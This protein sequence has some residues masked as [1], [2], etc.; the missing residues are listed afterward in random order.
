MEDNFFSL[1][2]H[3]L[4][5]TQVMARVRKALGVELPLRALFEAPTVMTLARQVEQAQRGGEASTPMERRG[6]DGVLPLSFAQQ[7]LWFLEQL[8]PGNSDYN[9]PGALRLQGVL[10]VGALERSFQ[11]LVRRHE[12]LRT[13]LPS[14]EGEPRQSILAESTLRMLHVDLSGLNAAERQTEVERLAREEARAPFNL[15]QGPLLRVTLLKLGAQ[16]H[17]LLLTMHHIVSDGWSLGVLVKEV[18]ALYGAYAAGKES[19]L[20]ELPLQYADYSAW[21]RERLS[22]EVLDAQLGYWKTKLQGLP[23]ALE[24]PTDRPRPALRTSKGAQYGVKLDGA[25]TRELKALS[26]KQGATLY[27]TLLAAFQTLLHRYTGQVDVAV[28]SPIAN[29]TRVET[30]GLIGFFVNTLVMRG[31][32]SGAPGFTE[33]L[34]RVKG[35]T[36]EAYAHQEVPFEKLVEVL[37]PAR[38]LARTALFQ[39]MLVLQNAPAPSLELGA[40][41]LE[42]LTVDSGT[43]KFDLTLSLVDGEEL[44]GFLEYSTDLFEEE[45]V[46]RL[47]GNFRRLLEAIIA[48]PEQSIATLPLL[49]EEE[50]Q[51]L[52]VTWNATA[53]A[54]PVDQTIHELF[55]AQA[56]R[57]PDAVALIQGPRRISY[58]E[59]NRRANQVAH[60][61]LRHGVG[62]DARVGLFIRRSPEV[63][64][65]MLGVLKAGGA[66]VPLDPGYPVER[67]RFVASDARLS[68]VLAHGERETALVSPGAT[69]QW[70]DVDDAAVAAERGTNPGLNVPPDAAAYIIYTSGSTGTPKGVVGLHRGAVNRFRWMWA[71]YPA[72]SDEVSALKTSSNF[73]DSVWETFGLML[74]GV[75]SV[76]L[77]EET[78]RSPRLLVEAL[79]AERVTRIVLVPSL[80]SVLLKDEPQLAQRLSQLRYWTSSGEALPLEL[81][82]LCEEVLPGRKLLNLYGSSEV[83]ADSTAVEVTSAQSVPGVPIGRP[84]DN[85][86]VYLLDARLQP[87]PL[88]VAGELYIGGAGLARGYLFRPDLTAERFIP[89][90]YSGVPG[91]RLYRTGDLCRYRRDGTLD[92]IGRVDRQVKLRGMR[93]ELGEVE[94]VLAQ[95]P[96][97]RDAVVALHAATPGGPRLV[98]YTVAH[99]TP[100]P[101]PAELRQYLGQQL[102]EYM[103]PSVFVALERL[104]LT[105]NGKVDRKALPA[106]TAEGLAVAEG[107]TAPRTAVEELLAGAWAE[108]L[109]LER[110][111]V[112][113]NFFALGGHSL[114]ATQVMARVRKALGV[115]LPLRALFETPTVATLARQVE[116][117]QRG[118][119]ASTPIE[120]RG[121]DGVLPLSFSQQ[122][123]WFLE[124]LQPGSPDYNIPAVLQLRGTLDVSALERSFQEVVRRHEVLRTVL[125]SVEGEPRQSIL[126]ESTLHLRQVDLSAL[127]VSAPEVERLAREEARSPFNLE[128]GPLLRVTLLKLGEQ[129]HVLLLTMHHI[130][131]DGWSLGVLVKEVTA[132]YG[133]YVAGKE[134]PLAELPL[135]YADYSAWQR[136][137]LSGEV[138]EAQLGYWKTKLQGL[139][140]ALELPTDRSRPALRTSKGAQYGVKLDGA[141]TR[142]L[143]ALSRKQGATLYMT[144]LAAFQTLLHRYTGQVDVAVGSP[145]AN[146]TR[147]ETEGLIGFFVNTLVMRG[148]LSGAPG[149]TELLGRVKGTTLEA[150]AH[151]EVPFE[152]LVE[153]LAP[154]RDLARTALFQV[155]LVLQNAPAPSLEL[156]AVKLETLAVDSGT[157][158]FDL[159]LSLVDGEELEGWLEY[160]TDLF[161]EETVARLMGNFR[162]LLQGIVAK[163]EQ[164]IA[165]LPLLSEEERQ[166]LLVTWNATATARPVD[167]TI[168]ELFEAQAARTPDAVALIAGGER[169]SYGDLAQRARVRA[170]YLQSLGVGPETVVALYLERSAETVIWL[171]AILEAGGVY[172][173]LDL[174]APRER[175]AFMLEDARASVLLTTSSLL[176][177]LPE[178]AARVVCSDKASAAIASASPVAHVRGHSARLAYINYTSG[179]TGRPKGVSIPHGAV[180]R[181]A[182]ASNYIRITREDVLLQFAPVS[183]DA[184]TFEIWAGLLNGASVAVADAGTLSLEELGR[185][186]RRDKVTTLWLTAPLFHQMV[187]HHLDD[188]RGVRNLLAGGDVLSPAHVLRAMEALPGCRIINGYGPTE[189]TTFTCCGPVEVLRDGAPVPIGRPLDDTQVY[190]L[191]GRLQ[192]VPVGVPG[193]LYTGGAGLARGYLHNPGLTGEKFIP[194]PFGPPG[195]RLYRT[196]DLARYLP[197]GR[198]EFLGRIDQ[199]VKIRG[200]RIEPAEIEAVLCDHPGV[201]AGV[202]EVIHTATREKR[203]V[204]Y[205]V[206]RSQPAPTSTELRQYLGQ[207]LPE[208]MVPSVFMLL[209]AMP[210]TSNGKVDRKALPAPTAEGL[211]VAEGYTAPRTAVEELLA[212]AWAEVL[213]LERVGVE[214]NFFALGGHSLLATQVMARVR[215][216]LGVELPLRAL[217][218][219]PTVATLARQV[220]QAQRGGEA[221][222][223][224]ERRGRDGVLPLSFAQQ[225]LWFLEQ[226]QPGNSDYNVPGA[227]RLQGV[228]D[229]GALERSFQE[230]VRRHE[231][232]CTVLPSVEGEPRQSI[233][234]ESSLRLA[235]VDLSGLNATERQAEV[236]RLAREEARA[237]FNLEQGPLLRVTLLKLDAQEHVLL[238]TM[239]HIVS[240]GWSLGVLVKEVSALYG[241]YVAGKESPLAELPL[242]YADYSAWQRERLQGEV[243]DAQLGYWKTKLQGL[244]PALELPTDRPRPALRTSKGAQYGVKLD[245]A[246]TRELKALSRK[247]GATL[248]MTLL[249]AFQTLL[250]RYTGQVDVAVGSPIANRTRVETEGLIGFFV[251]TLVM[252]GDLSGA[253]GFTELLG[254]VKGTTLE[255]YAHQE[256]PFEKLVEVLAPARDLAR[257]ALF[258]VM[259]V[260]QNAPAPSLELG[261][262]KLETLAVDSGTSKFDL[263]LS[264]V[265]GEELEGW[266][267]YSTDLFEEETVAR[268]MGNFRR[269]LQGI[270]AKPEQS[271][272]TLPLLSEEERQTLLVTWNGQTRPA[273]ST[274]YVHQLF[275]D[276]A[277]RAPDELAVASEE[278]ALSYREVN[279]RA[280]RLARHLQSLGVGPEV[281]VG[282]LME[283]SLEMLVG[284][285]G[286]LKA[287]GA[288]VPIAPSFPAQRVRY[289]LEDSRVPVLLTVSA[290]RDA[291]SAPGVH[292]LCLD[293]ADAVLAAQDDSNLP[294]AV[295]LENRVYVIYTS[296][297]TGMPKGVVVE[298]RQVLNYLHA[299]V[300]R[301]GLKPGAQYAM[302]QP[303]AVDSCKTVFIPA[304]CAGGTLHVMSRERAS[305]PFA[306]REY[307]QRRHIDVLKITPSHLAALVDACPQREMFPHAVLALGG[308]A[309]HW[310][311]IRAVQ[312]LAPSTAFHIH[313]GP[314]ETTVGMLTYAIRP[315]AV[316]RGVRVPLGRPLPNTRVFVLDPAMQPV[317]VGVT[318]EIFIG[319]ACVTRGYQDRP[320]LTAERY[321][322]DPFSATPG[323][324]LY[325]TGDQARWLPEG[326]I[327]FLGRTDHQVKIRGFRIELGEV[328]A[329][330]KQHDVVQSA[331]VI[332]R[333]TGT[334]DKRLVAYVVPAR[335]D[336]GEP[337]ALS[338]ALLDF[339]R[340]RLPDYMLPAEVMLL[341]ALPL[342]AMGKVALNALPVPSGESAPREAVVPPRTVLQAQLVEVWET[343][344]DTRPVGITDNFFQLGGHSLLAV[345]LLAAI[346]HRF[347]RG[348]SLA[349]LFRNPTIAHVA[350]LLESSAE[351]RRSP[352]MVTLRTGGAGTP[353]FLVHAVGGNVLGYVGLAR[354]LGPDRPVYGLQAPA[355]DAP[356][357]ALEEL[358]ALYNEEL[359]RVQPQGPYLLGGWSMG[360]VLAYEMARQ[361]TEQGQEVAT[362]ALLDTHLPPGHRA[363]VDG[364]DALPVMARFAAELLR[365]RQQDPGPFLE[366]F[367]R[368]EPEQQRT[369]SLESLRSAGVLGEESSV[370]DLRELLEVFTRNT[371]ALEAYRLR[372]SDLRAVMFQATRSEAP[373]G[374]AREWAAWA[375]GGVE[376][377]EVPGDHFTIL[378][379]AGVR[380]LA[381]Q[382]RRYLDAAD[383]RR[384][385]GG[386]RGP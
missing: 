232:L 294:N 237:P 221:S 82:R 163:P 224:M 315:S 157:S 70:V 258:Q 284:V 25:L 386:A 168:H 225:R 344:L 91:A 24:L 161:E 131:S 276:H 42:M 268:L 44:E 62:P 22:G 116:Q 72:G 2:G 148:D 18:T 6:R 166:T 12:V 195:S 14:V 216:A 134:S 155:M 58:A 251:N 301:F 334:G 367:L 261:E 272:A 288:Y 101:T 26:R 295:T 206:P 299:I 55:E 364:H 215:K 281:G 210:L 177:R 247:Q 289:I 68:L 245:G 384:E 297:S 4:L 114:L 192:P 380:E 314:T 204:A 41:K 83:S 156:G 9:V 142:E 363:V 339:L 271:I 124:Q 38:D 196:G 274:R 66:Y 257:T 150:Y 277:E 205:V 222:T 113:D 111:G 51:T 97:L 291:G 170:G 355:P 309:S 366:R 40:V 126:A 248:Y 135:Q 345:K 27:M 242:Q 165:T 239:H 219:T 47:M 244:P 96:A 348:I 337:R 356:A 312:P 137:R 265:D 200:F 329:A 273:P 218:E 304:M 115:E 260:L 106:P 103:V 69:L 373:E 178:S 379:G 17:V 310:E 246:L 252:R 279:R 99:Q 362:L 81:V 154:A 84:I 378:Q 238:L 307:F 354:E 151:Q 280:N 20:S 201:S 73:V 365:M 296:G 167:Q 207:Q 140:P 325:R 240:D 158:K 71:L 107:Y 61:L 1:G 57:T 374:L 13:V 105:P 282:I 377:H 326:D 338:R 59:L 191:D 120:R 308:E 48:K 235:H 119:E 358:A 164:S 141:L 39:V 236:E 233:L 112:E 32:L 95:H 127:E 175:L 8:Q 324:R 197:D 382:L 5:A 98:A 359:R 33:L 211:V 34:G 117:A 37:A 193:E 368:L 253:P 209:E 302:L 109:G 123:L 90:L 180:V 286:I 230:L 60:H 342:T 266:L 130:V 74:Q 159:T 322:P 285:L 226:L 136:E 63:V 143:K 231:V 110:V 292:V 269:L 147:V 371:R 100:A 102:P 241:A 298:Q 174:A 21:Q 176:D 53:T 187:D 132:L 28:G 340:E 203:L 331:V 45:T 223:P 16:E 256:V 278:G 160:S 330:L 149:F 94:S 229:V 85:T 80:L 122:R 186:L 190:L 290:L 220:E 347:G 54:R 305:D 7:R 56:A 323:G 250:H 79:E 36:L 108:V 327:E 318:G 335:P 35:T 30:E 336:A 214:D 43:S 125:P 293:Q 320:E 228:L 249:A 369:L 162:R 93:I 64:I 76:I 311:W 194:N 50:R 227:L 264:L 188:L 133:A 49:S 89:D 23:P 332:A 287:G 146:R 145:I 144:L 121:R 31:D 328:E 243:L 198:V 343:V 263:T 88:G 19:P 183:F 118:S 303:L 189:N 317:P 319:G 29:R 267:E 169:I 171:L 182:L 212:G 306:V 15:E 381:E 92:Y 78:V 259:L 46:A 181:L 213:G 316:Q 321:V 138:L 185:G 346:R 300:E 67:L 385:R 352:V 361:L 341:D 383:S 153:V 87:V 77:S 65:T 351:P 372:R 208:Y 86:Q 128:Q 75:P 217:F 360:G 10:D 313:Y 152:K 255:A 333:E 234:A 262:V 139:P 202:V 283:P 11:E 350:T 376:R 3:S 104:P 52:L 353:L 254:R 375:T 349:G 179:S 357:R 173:P 172:L 129:E 199:Q 275:E 270:V 370:E 184:A